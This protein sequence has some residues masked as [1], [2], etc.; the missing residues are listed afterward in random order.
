MLRDLI[1]Q[2]SS[3]LPSEAHDA[4]TYLAGDTI[5]KVLVGVVL[6]ELIGMAGLAAAVAVLFRRLF[7]FVSKALESSNASSTESL[8]RFLKAVLGFKDEL[9]DV[10]STLKESL[11]ELTTRLDTRMARSDEQAMNVMHTVLNLLIAAYESTK[12][13]HGLSESSEEN[14]DKEKTGA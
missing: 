8:D 13:R 11:D 2:A 4:M 1:L 10:V 3:L 5:Q 14:S 7:R 6:L 12:R 9:H